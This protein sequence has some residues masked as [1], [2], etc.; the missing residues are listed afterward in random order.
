[1]TV[2]LSKLGARSRV[3]AALIGYKAGFGRGWVPRRREPRRSNPPF[4]GAEPVQAEGC[5]GP[6][7]AGTLA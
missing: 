6:A 5:A 1:M 2:V 4:E 3:E 7:D